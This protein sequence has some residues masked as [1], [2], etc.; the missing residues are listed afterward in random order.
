MKVRANK[1]NWWA[2]G[3]LREEPFESRSR[4]CETQNATIGLWMGLCLLLAW[5]LRKGAG[6]V[7][8]WGGGLYFNT[9][10]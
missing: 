8:G 1:Q 6:V 2:F 5:P 10:L 3:F 4:Y 9:Q 7:G